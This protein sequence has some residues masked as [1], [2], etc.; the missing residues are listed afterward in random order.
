MRRNL[1]VAALQARNELGQIKGAQEAARS[2]AEIVKPQNRHQ[3]QNGA[4]HGVEN[5]FH[6][7]VDAARVAPYADQEIHGN[8]RQFPENEEEEQVER[9]ENADHGRF[10]YQQR[11]E[12]TFHVFMD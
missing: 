10:D 8:Q 5:K 3:H 4:K 11:D 9:N 2:A 1:D 6:G 7:G 12:E